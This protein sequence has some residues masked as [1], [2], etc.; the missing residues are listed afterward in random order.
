MRNFHM[1]AGLPRA[2]STLLCQILNS[3]PTFHVTPTSGVLDMLKLMRSGFSQNPTWRAQKRLEIYENF[4]RGMQGFVEGFFHDSKVVFDKNRGW[5]ANIKLIDSV[6]DDN[7]SKVIWLYRDPVEIISSIE[8]QYEKTYLLENMDES[9]APGAFM[10]LDRRVG[11]YASPEGIIGQP[12]EFLK[13]ALEM[14]YGSRI[15]LIKYYD[16]TN[17]TQKVLNTI[18]NFIGETP[19]EY[20]LQNIKQST[21]EFDGIYNYKFL[22]QIREGEIKWKR[23]DYKM[24]NKFIAAINERF[25]ALNSLVLND[26]PTLLLNLPPLKKEEETFKGS[27]IALDENENL[28]IPSTNHPIADT[29]SPFV[30]PALETD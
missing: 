24:E 8:A 11:T 21:W 6:F 16:L 18:H 22:H 19:Y 23:G 13:D 5:P 3:N 14:G 2:G 12:V 25:V 20:D 15:L 26:D 7:K 9:A 17:D 4:R 1:I 29:Q 27:P 10:T 30:A 28:T